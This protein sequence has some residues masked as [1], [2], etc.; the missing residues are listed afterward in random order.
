MSEIETVVILATGSPLHHSQLAYSRARSMLPAL[1]KPLVARAMDRL[2]RFSSIRRYIVV[3]GE[4]EGGIPPY[5]HD[6]WMANVSVD[7]VLYSATSTL[8]N[9]LGGI[10]RRESKPFILA[11]YNS[12]TH[13]NFP[14]RLIERYEQVGDHLILSGSAITL[15]HGS[16]HYFA[17]VEQQRVVKLMPDISS[18]VQPFILTDFMLCGRAFLD[19]LVELPDLEPPLFI[20]EPMTLANHYLESGGEIYAADASWTLQ[21]DSDYDL[22]TLNRLLLDEDQDAHI[23][24]ELPGSIQIIPPV[25]IDPRVSVGRGAQIGP[26]AYLE[27][28]CSIGHNAVVRNAVILQ[29]V[30]IPAGQIVA[31]AVIATRMRIQA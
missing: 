31:D 10:A 25:R 7:F 8:A 13:P 1:G 5:L 30:Q 26:Y 17:Q 20:R 23:L 28:G 18:T 27:S 6:H 24:S 12:F 3:V 14:Q 11:S 15:S 29:N 19:Y 21:I 22:L 16:G 9:T 2:Y 4:D